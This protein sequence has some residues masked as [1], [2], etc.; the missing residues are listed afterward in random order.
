MT[1]SRFL[2]SAVR[3]RT[4]TGGTSVGGSSS[5]VV[6]IMPDGTVRFNDRNGVTQV[7]Q[8]PAEYTTAFK[9]RMQPSTGKIGAGDVESALY[10]LID[11]LIART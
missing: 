7:I 10:S 11:A 6:S 2:R 8:M 3:T 5:T 1:T 4:V 9:N